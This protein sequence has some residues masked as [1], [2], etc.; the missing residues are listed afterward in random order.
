MSN[1]IKRNIAITY[2]TLNDMVKDIHLKP[3]M[4]VATLGKNAINDSYGSTYKIY[5]YTGGTVPTGSVLIANGT[6]RAEEIASS[7]TTDAMESIKKSVQSLANKVTTLESSET[8]TRYTELAEEE[9]AKNLRENNAV[10]TIIALDTTGIEFKRFYNGQKC[11]VVHDLN[12][13]P[14]NEPEEPEI[15]PEEETPTEGEG[16]NT[17]ETPVEREE[18]GTGE[19]GTGETGTGET[20][21]GETGSGETTGEITEPSTEE[22]VVT[23]SEGEVTEETP[24]DETA[25]IAETT[26]AT[27]EDPEVAASVLSDEESGEPV[28]LAEEGTDTTTDTTTDG[29]TDGT[30]GNE[31]TGDGT[32][33]EGSTEEGGEEVPPTE[34]EEVPTSIN[35]DGI[36]VEI[37]ENIATIIIP[38]GLYSW[39]VPRCYELTS[40]GYNTMKINDLVSTT[41]NNMDNT[42]TFTIDRTEYPAIHYYN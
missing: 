15:P 42:I 37:N 12:G 29:T 27:A 32:G 41:I 34:E 28:A 31:T 16:E 39:V 20:G 6:L 36:T 10:D 18:T 19:T 4:I 14:I 2:D 23:A 3:N 8:I 24:V 38:I 40:Y 5:K 13:D 25:T 30:T 33:E 21:T 7:N 1:V 35:S 22:E 9:V 17:G 11:I 26:D